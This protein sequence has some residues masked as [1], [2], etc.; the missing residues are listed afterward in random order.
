MY[1]T[2]TTGCGLGTKLKL[3]ASNNLLIPTDHITLFGEPK[4]W[5]Y[6]LHSYAKLLIVQPTCNLTKHN[7]HLDFS[8]QGGFESHC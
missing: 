1:K 8:Y 6:K 5:N 4:N 2:P 3:G 7:S